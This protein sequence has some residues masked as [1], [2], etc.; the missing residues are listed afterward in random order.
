MEFNDGREGRWTLE[1]FPTEL[2]MSGR[3]WVMEGAVGW[4][5][6]GHTNDSTGS[7][8]VRPC[9]PAQNYWSKERASDLARPSE[10]L[11]RI[12]CVGSGGQA[13]S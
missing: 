11:Q 10:S 1:A 3:V 9:F 8:N 12:Q 4:D 7:R 6:K 5:G 2:R 13:L